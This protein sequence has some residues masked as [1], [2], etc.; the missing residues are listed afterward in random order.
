[1]R[2]FKLSAGIVFDT[3]CLS[4]FLWVKRPDL[5]SQL[6]QDKILIPDPVVDELSNLKNTGYRWVPEILDRQIAAGLFRALPIPAV[7]DIASEYYRLTK[8]AMKSMGSGEAAALAYVR[9]RGGTVASNNLSDVNAYCRSFEI[10][11]VSTDDILCLAKV[12]GLITMIEGEGL[13]NE[14]KNRRRKLP[15]Y[16]FGE[17]MRRFEEGLA[18]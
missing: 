13:W 8:T 3:D 5:L 14:M 17:A 15:A 2:K 18:K 9:Y 11:L 4:S 6:F 1:M 7:G 12:Q 10:E 16:D